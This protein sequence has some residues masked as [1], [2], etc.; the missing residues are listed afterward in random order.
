MSN[1]RENEG[2]TNSWQKKSSFVGG[3]Q[4]TADPLSSH[5][6]QPLLGQQEAS[7]QYLGRVVVELWDD[8]RQVDDSYKIVFSVDAIDGNAEAL[9]QRIAPALF[10]RAQKGPIFKTGQKE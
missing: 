10:K 2:P 9:L 1:D 5:Q 3:P 8:G 6:G 4:N 7:S